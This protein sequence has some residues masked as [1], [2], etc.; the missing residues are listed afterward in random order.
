MLEGEKER[1]S[2]GTLYVAERCPL[3]DSLVWVIAVEGDAT[4]AE[5]LPRVDGL[6]EAGGEEE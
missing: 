3:C 5:D 4:Q 1:R 6:F 2:D